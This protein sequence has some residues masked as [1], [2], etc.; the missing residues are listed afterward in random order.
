MTCTPEMFS[1]LQLFADVS[2]IALQ[3]LGQV[4]KLAVYQ[5]GQVIMLE[6][7]RDAPV[8]FVC[9]GAVRVFRTNADGREQTI[10]HL[11]TEDVFNM[12][13]AFAHSHDAPASAMA[14]G[15]VKLI[16]IS[17][18]D[19]RRV[20]SE[21]AEIALAVLRDLSDKLRYF[22]DLTHD[23]SLRSVR[24][25]LAR[26]LLR[27]ADSQHHLPRRTHEE[28]AAQI[29]TAREVVS[30]TMR[31]F[32]NEGFIKIQPHTIIILNPPALKRE[33]DP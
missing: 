30:R 9:E 22:V 3:A 19:F 2:P 11:R 15:H 12:P 20:V 18:R 21:N 33:A 31:A 5:D 4:A 26:F 29:G 8:F 10:I 6:E 13:T 27:Q 32:V 14:I 28:I 7:D 1:K 23:L 25:R 17:R 24:A 16:E